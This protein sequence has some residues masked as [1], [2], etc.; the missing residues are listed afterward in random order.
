MSVVPAALV[1]V[2]DVALLNVI[3]APVSPTPSPF[4]VYSVFSEFQSASGI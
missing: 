3:L 2:P 4:I 1:A